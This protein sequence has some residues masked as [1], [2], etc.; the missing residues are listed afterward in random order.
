M[1]L[2]DAPFWSYSAFF[3]KGRKWKGGACVGLAGLLVFQ[4]LITENFNGIFGKY[5]VAVHPLF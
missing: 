4:R 3:A 1:Y 2:L 5:F